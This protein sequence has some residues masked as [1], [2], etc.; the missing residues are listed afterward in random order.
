[1]RRPEC[2]SGPRCPSREGRGSLWFA[3][4]VEKA[5]RVRARVGGKA[6]EAS[7]EERDRGEAGLGAGSRAV[8][9]C[10]WW[11]AGVGVSRA[12]EGSGAVREH[13]SGPVVRQ[14]PEELGSVQDWGLPHSA[15]QDGHRLVVCHEVLSKLCSLIPR[16]SGPPFGA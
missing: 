4:R 2:G 13:P 12:W 5:G 8:G 11:E 10:G 6:C 7:S 1:M 14:T 15:V 9:A 16:S 3:V